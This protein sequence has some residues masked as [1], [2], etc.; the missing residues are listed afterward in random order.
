MKILAKYGE[1]GIAHVYVAE[2][3]SGKR[4]EFVESTK[5]GLGY[6]NKCVIIISTLFGCPVG[7]KFCDAGSE[8]YG[9]KLSKEDM[10]DQINY[11]IEN[12]F[13]DINP[14]SCKKLKVQ[15]A[16]MGEPAF[17]MDVL[18]VL[19]ELGTRYNVNITPSISTIAPNSTDEFFE[20]L[21]KLK[22]ELF[23][24]NFQMQFSIHS[25]DQ[26]YRDW[27]IP[28]KKWSFERIAEYIEKFYDKDGKKVTLNFAVTEKT[29]IDV[30]VAAQVFPKDK[31]LIK[32]TP[33]NPTHS[34][35]K[36]SINSTREGEA[37]YNKIIKDFESVGFDTV[38][39]IG[40]NQENNI[41]SNCGQYL[42]DYN[43]SVK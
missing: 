41:G 10:L 12:R 34:A 11:V 21:L 33:V 3:S 35:E 24:Q 37:F 13:P 36:H 39:S 30:H 8:N 16:R 19:K 17:N 38:L 15:F 27:L 29:P 9:G 14:E 25:T 2:V 28:V 4:I 40:E 20:G 23:P 22:K 26:E 43:K 31:C 6:K 18:E 5:P 7:C 1:E 42:L 32:I